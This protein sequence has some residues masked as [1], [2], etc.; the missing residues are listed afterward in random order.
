MENEATFISRQS[1]TSTP[2]PGPVSPGS[3]GHPHPTPCYGTIIPNRIFVGGID[4]STQE[5]DLRRFFSERGNVKEVKIVT[6]RA[7]VSRG[8]GFVTFATQEDAQ[9]ILSE[10]DRLYFKDR[11]LNVSQAIRRQQVEPHIGS[12]SVSSPISVIPAVGGTVYVAATADYAYTYHNGVAYFHAP[13]MNPPVH[14]WPLYSV[15]GAPIMMAHQAAQAYPQSAFHHFQGPTQCIT[16]PLQ[17][18]MP[19]VSVPSNSVRYIQ[20]SEVLY[21]PREMALDGGCAPPPAHLLEPFTPE[22]YADQMVQPTYHH[23]Y[24][25]SPGGMGPP[26]IQ[27]ETGQE[28]RFQA[29]RR[30]FARSPINLKTRYRRGP[31]YIHPHKE[32]HIHMASLS[33]QPCAEPLE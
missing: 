5:S 3:S 24:A 15:S 8:Y 31:R 14:H 25:Q 32:Y 9:K 22:L 33:T 30:G 23:M 19:Q 6:D 26:V 27:Q 18:N 2:S 28:Q 16:G 7:G 11:K 10:A 20:P 29:I 4:F 1:Q 17:W 12:I 13:E 21:Q